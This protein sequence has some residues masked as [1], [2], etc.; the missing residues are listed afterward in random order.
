MRIRRAGMRMVV[1]AVGV[2][3]LVLSWS[4]TAQA[5]VKLQYK[6]PEGKKL[7]YKRSDRTRQLLTLMGMEIPS[8]DRETVVLSL[9]VGKRRGNGTVPVE[10]KVESLHAERSLPGGINLS[11][12][13][14]DPNAKIDN[15]TFAFLG[16]IYKLASETVFTVVLDD[17]NKVKAIEG[18][19]KMLEK[20]D[21]LD[22][23]T[24]DL[25][26]DRFEADKLKR[27]F[28]NSARTC[29]TSWPAPASP[30]NGPR[31]TI[32]AWARRSHFARNTNTW[33]PRKRGTRRSTRSQ[34]R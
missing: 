22:P 25:I 10:E 8:D 2:A 27:K 20:V 12:D 34:A 13:S 19:E 17:Q 7:S 15:P 30:G 4:E 31:S 26:R 3:C 28:E 9:T 29:R 18:A 11:Y 33:A 21:K 14:K 5:Q 6:Y 16:D 32:P 24:R 1:A 23:Q